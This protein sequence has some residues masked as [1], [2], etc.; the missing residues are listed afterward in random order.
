MEEQHL[1]TNDEAVP[2]IQSFL[3]EMLDQ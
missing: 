3:I 1:M 2:A